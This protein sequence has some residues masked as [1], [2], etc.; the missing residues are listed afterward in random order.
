MRSPGFA[1]RVAA[2]V[3]LVAAATVGVTLAPARGVV[4]DVH[5]LTRAA[6]ADAIDPALG[7]RNLRHLIFIVQ[8]NR[9]FDHYFGTF[10]G[11]NGLP[12]RPD[13]SFAVCVPDPQAGRCRRPFHDAG[14]HDAG[15]PHS[16]LA[17][18]LS[19]N[20]G[21]M[22]GFIEVQQ[23]MYSTCRKHPTNPECIAAA[24]D[25]DGRPDVMGFHA[26]REI[27]N[28]WAWA[29][30]YVLHDRMFAASDSY[31]LPAHLYLVSGWSARC[32]DLDDVASCVSDQRSPDQR[33]EPADG[34]RVPYL[35]ADITWLLY[36]HGV[37]WAY[38]VGP[39]TCVR[40]PCPDDETGATSFNKNPLAGF[41]T[42][43]ETG[44]LGRIRPYGDYFER[45]RSGRLPAVAWVVPT[46]T[47]SEHPPQ[48]VDDGQAFV[49][50]L[51]NAAMQGPDWERTAI[52]LIWDDWGG[53]YDHVRPPVVDAG[54][55]GLR[56]PS[57][58]I[59][60]W[61]DR[62]LD[63]DHQTLSYDAYLKLI[64]DRFLGGQRLDPETD[65]WWD[66]RP[67]IREEVGILGDLAKEF[68]F[69]QRP[70]PP[71]ILEPRPSG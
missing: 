60:P 63:I 25:A 3:A 5:L 26:A 62:D 56:V 59:S 55:Y 64:E 41:T 18:D 66:P 1:R 15:G 4:A 32:P 12:R 19:I 43:Q 69:S 27:P 17:S 54:G 34:G 70:I 68:D 50:R 57:M 31:T 40:A 48:G 71:L 11:A 9:S 37:T 53:F 14:V 61:A 6:S 24:R 29:R 36:R 2:V 44:Q 67:T 30:R 28:Y 16:E 38:Y 46:K 42:V 23:T 52:F 65:G 39:S 35:W 21:A 8:E 22:D 7:I 51:V 20:G 58:L 47:T 13:G 10:P 49:T 45:A 33:W